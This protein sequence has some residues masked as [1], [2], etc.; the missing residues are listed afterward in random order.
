M[1]IVAALYH[2]TRFPDPEALRGPLLAACRQH[3]ICGTLLLA[4]E[5]INGTIAG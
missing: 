3:G 5:G 1:L 2:F 4:P